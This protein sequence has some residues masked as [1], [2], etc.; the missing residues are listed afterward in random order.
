MYVNWGFLVSIGLGVF[1]GNWIAVPMF[2]KSVTTNQMFWVGII[3][4]LLVVAVNLI[5]KVITYNSYIQSLAEA[6][7]K[8][9]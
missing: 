8:L 9:Q 1:F 7:Q 6:L 2:S 5:Y 4:G 3:S